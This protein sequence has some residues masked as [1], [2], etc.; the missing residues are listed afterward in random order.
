MKFKQITYYFHFRTPPNTKRGRS[1]GQRV[2]L[3]ANSVTQGQTA[4]TA[5]RRT[6]YNAHARSQTLQR[7]CALANA[8]THARTA[9]HTPHTRTH[10]RMHTRTAHTHRTHA[11]H[12]R[13]AHT[14]AH[15]R[16][17]AHTCAWVLSCHATRSDGRAA[18]SSLI[19]SNLRACVR[20][21]VRVCAWL[22][23]YAHVR[24]C[25]C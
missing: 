20:V 13:T 11:P 16:A 12:T 5:D 23:V 22:R 2:P 1:R 3:G 18:S 14:H 24:A 9:P 17:H 15:A 4:K 10:T 19:A 7:T 8:R 6:R 21:R 25:V